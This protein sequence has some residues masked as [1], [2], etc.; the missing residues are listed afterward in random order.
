MPGASGWAG[1]NKLPGQGKRRRPVTGPGDG[2][3]WSV[4]GEEYGQGG[5]AALDYALVQLMRPFLG[6]VVAE[7]VEAGEAFVQ[8]V[9]LPF[10]LIFQVGKTGLKFL[11]YEVCIHGGYSMRL[12]VV[13]RCHTGWQ[14]LTIVS[15]GVFLY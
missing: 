2:G 10:Q 15:V 14:T 11:V 9:Q 7:G 1:R 3:E 8:V 4:S 13:I 6:F 12:L 5:A